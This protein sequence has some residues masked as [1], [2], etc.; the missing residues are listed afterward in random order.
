MHGL[1]DLPGLT[2]RPWSAE[3]V[4]ALVRHVERIHAAEGLSHPPGPD[5]FRWLL[6]QREFDPATDGL[7][8]VDDAGEIL[9]E[10]G[11]WAHV[12]P[13]GARCFVWADTTPDLA[14]LRPHLVRWAEARATAL[15]AA[16]PPGTD[17][18]IRTS[19]ET[20]R[21]ALAE[22]FLQAGFRA[23]R[24]F[25]TMRRSLERLPESA[26][27][28][29]GIAVVPW[30]PDLDEPAREASNASFADHW[31]SLPMSAGTW[32]GMYRDSRTFRPGLSFLALDG[33]R[34]VSLSL[35]HQEEAGEVKIHRVGTVQTH[36][37]R[38]LAGHLVPRSLRAAAEIGGIEW[39]SLDVDESSGSNAVRLY[40]SLGFETSDRS[41]QYIKEI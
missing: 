30:S 2:W 34:V 25:V 27:A 3:D 26:P 37:G 28:P 4:D 19:I 6:G 15:L 1:P 11:A 36:R 14:G 5:A 7:V 8:A 40:A 35:V 41:I 22:V 12:T 16:A 31:G 24:T 29:T 33:E 10:A 9:G 23:G 32:R 13:A 20:H 18:V 17:R 39:A 38:G 21:T